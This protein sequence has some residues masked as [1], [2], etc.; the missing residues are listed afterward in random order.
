MENGLELTGVV[1][2][3]LQDVGAEKRRLGFEPREIGCPCLKLD[4]DAG[5]GRSWG[6]RVNR[7]TPNR[8][9]TRKN[10][11]QRTKNTSKLKVEGS[12]CFVEERLGGRE[13][14]K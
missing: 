10:P 13:F 11:L 1:R 14:E 7:Y 5:Q 6:L 4:M 12:G 2:Q 9:R 8:G 3:D